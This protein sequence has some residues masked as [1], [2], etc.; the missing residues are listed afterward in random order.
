MNLLSRKDKFGVVIFRQ[1]SI[2]GYGI[3]A[4]VRNLSN[5]VK[6]KKGSRTPTQ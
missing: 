1:N 4:S 5:L 3:G 2:D 6:V